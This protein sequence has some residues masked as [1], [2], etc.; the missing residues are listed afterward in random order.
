METCGQA[1]D[2]NP[3]TML[4]PRATRTARLFRVLRLRTHTPQVPVVT[5]R[6]HQ[7][8]EGVLVEARAARDR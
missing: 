4:G 7:N 2:G 1:P 6:F 8:S 3:S 5:A